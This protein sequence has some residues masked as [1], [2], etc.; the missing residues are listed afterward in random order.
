MQK[1]AKLAGRDVIVRG[2][3]NRWQAVQAVHLLGLIAPGLLLGQTCLA[4][5]LL[6]LHQH[7]LVSAR[8]ALSPFARPVLLLLFFTCISIGCL[9]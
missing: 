8:L 4:A 3:L 5:A 2:R 1:A 6:H 7:L 9:C